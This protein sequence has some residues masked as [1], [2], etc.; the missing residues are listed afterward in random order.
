MVNAG[1]SRAEVSL[2]SV[3]QAFKMFVD[4]SQGYYTYYL[5][6]VRE[7]ADTPSIVALKAGALL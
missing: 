3:D 1:G 7:Y 4:A 2:L 5:C 6:D